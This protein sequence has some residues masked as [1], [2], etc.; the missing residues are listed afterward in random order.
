MEET[1][2]KETLGFQAE[3]KQLLSLMIHSLYSNKE[4]TLRELVSNASDACDKL[5]FEALTD[6]ALYESDTELRIRIDYDPKGRTITVSDNGIG[7]S[8]QEVIEH[9]GTIAKSGTREFFQ[10]LTGD[11]AKDAHLIGQ[12]GVGF[13]SSFIVADRVTLTTRRAG[14]TAG[15]G[16]R[17]ESDGSGEY[18]IETAEKAARGTEVTLHLREGED[19]LLSGHRLRSIIRRYSDHITL[20]IVMKKE[21]WDKDTGENRVT[22]EDETVNQASALWARPKSEISE[23]QYHEFYKHVAHDFETPL[24]YSHNRVEGRKEYTQLLYIPSRAPFDLWDREHRH[25]VKLYVRRV[26]IM[27]DAEKLMPNYLRFVRGVID[28]SDLPLNV[29]REILQ[30]SKD[31]ETIRAGSVKRVLSMIE[32]LAGNHGEKFSVFWKEFG[33]V[34]KEG[35]GEDHANRERIARLLRFASTHKDSEEQDVSLADY[36]ARMKPEQEKIYYVSAES[37]AAAKN[38]PHLEVFR[39]KGVEVLLLSERV[40]EWMMSFLTE[41]EGKP[42]QSVARGALDLGKLEDEAEKKEQQKEADEFKDLTGK[43]KTALGERVKDVRVTLRLTDSPACLVA[44]EHDMTANLQRLL[45]AAG[46]KVPTSKPILEIN[47]HHPLVLRLK[48]EADDARFNDLSQVLFDQ[49]LLAEGGTLEDPAG[50][51]KRLNQLMLGISAK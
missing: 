25:G 16:V 17:W 35:M 49:S 40:D 39:R 9:I 3:V 32:D 27:D 42:L 24:A 45:K 15:H 47:P 13:Y 21:E 37:F 19:D 31:I 48:G 5:R 11:E 28:S 44:D 43:V 29:S 36:V 12:F 30:E 8:R 23:E 51:V 22:G 6:K 46:Q 26:F 1:R 10:R 7:M 20:P 50:F 2:T 18:T 14:L 4:I 33:A 34:F 38:S 41:F